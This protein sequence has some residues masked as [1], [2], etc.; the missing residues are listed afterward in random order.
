MNEADAIREQLGRDVLATQERFTAAMTRRL[1]A[2]TREERE[3]YLALLSI[4]VTPL[5]QL[6]K[7][8]RQVFQEAGS[9]ALPIL[10]QELSSR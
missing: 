8:L 7:P 3:R 4:L 9:Q 1:P 6:D 2:M 5:E 10:L